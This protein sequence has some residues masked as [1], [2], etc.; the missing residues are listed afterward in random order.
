MKQKRILYTLIALLISFNAFAQN[1]PELSIT[2]WE[3]DDIADVNIDQDNFI[4]SI[5]KIT[6]LSKEELRSPLLE[7]YLGNNNKIEPFESLKSWNKKEK[8][9]QNHIP[10]WWTAYNK[11]KHD[12]ESIEEYA[13]LNNMR[14]INL[15]V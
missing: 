6:D 15:N 3:N 10:K 12:A 4:K 8:L 7:T 13:N 2:L 11:I 1:E 5:G 14:V 9:N